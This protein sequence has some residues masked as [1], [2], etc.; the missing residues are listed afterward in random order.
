MSCHDKDPESR[1][2]ASRASE[3]CPNAP[4]DQVTAVGP[5]EPSESRQP[6][7]PYPQQSPFER[8]SGSAPRI[9]WPWSRDWRL[10]KAIRELARS[11][12]LDDARD[13]AEAARA[14]RRELRKAV[15]ARLRDVALARLVTERA[16]A[17]VERL[18]LVLRTQLE[19]TH[20]FA[21]HL[22][23][24]DQLRSLVPQEILDAVKERAFHEFVAAAGR[25][26]KA[27]TSV[28]SQ[29]P[30]EDT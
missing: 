14:L 10:C 29:A 6:L 2:P 7:E 1:P 19:M 15:L 5:W 8:I 18:D 3:A 26:G 22:Q 9:Q 16:G 12:Q 20:R 24:V 21:R 23:A 17:Q 11:T 4:F 25:I 30:R 27:E 28:R 13:A